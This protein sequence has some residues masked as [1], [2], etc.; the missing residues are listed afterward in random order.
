VRFR[1]STVVIAVV[2]AAYLVFMAL[3][4]AGIVGHHA[5]RVQAGMVVLLVL[6]V[7]LLAGDLARSRRRPEADR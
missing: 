5:G 6:L 4:F 1:T 3:E 7:A 2:I